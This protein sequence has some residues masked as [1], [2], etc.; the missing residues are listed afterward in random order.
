M[1]IHADHPSPT[2]TITLYLLTSVSMHTYVLQWNIFLPASLKLQPYGARQICL[3]L[4]LLLLLFLDQGTQFPGNE[5][6]TL[7]N[8]ILLLQFWPSCMTL[9]SLCPKI[10]HVL[11]KTQLHSSLLLFWHAP[12]GARCAICRHQPPQRTVLGQVDWFIQREVVGSQI[13]LDRV[14]PCDMRTP[15]WSLPVIWWGKLKSKLKLLVGHQKHP[16]Y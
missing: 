15:S 3:N 8:T 6:I 9:C 14:Q 7:C 1:Q 11:Q 4:L 10:I 12:P 5:K 13:V 2:P 16:T